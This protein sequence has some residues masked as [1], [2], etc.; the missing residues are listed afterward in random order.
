MKKAASRE[1][2]VSRARQLAAAGGHLNYATIGT[3]LWNEGYFQA[4]IWLDDIVLRGELKQLCDRARQ[5]IV[6]FPG[7]AA[8][9]A[10][11]RLVG[12]SATQGRGA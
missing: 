6:P 3:E 12:Y 10:T 2:V 7:A 11:T 1:T 8:R 4:R 5:A 9:D